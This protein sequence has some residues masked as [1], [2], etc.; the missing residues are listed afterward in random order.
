[1]YKMIIVD[2]EQFSREGMKRLLRWENYDIEIAAV[3][4]NAEEGIEVAKKI[5]PDIIITDI[6]MNAMD[7][8]TMLE[9]IKKFLKCEFI[10]ISGYSV[11]EYA[12]R[13]INAEV[14]NYLLKPVSR[15]DLE[16]AVMKCIMKIKKNT[17]QTMAEQMGNVEYTLDILLNEDIP[18]KGLIDFEQY[19]VAVI[20]SKEAIIK[21][22]HDKLAV[23]ESLKSRYGEV[24]IFFINPSELVIVI[25]AMYENQSVLLDFEQIYH[26]GIALGNN[27]QKFQ[28]VYGNARVAVNQAIRENRSAVLFG[29]DTVIYMNEFYFDA[30]SNIEMLLE[31]GEFEPM[32]T[33]ISRC[34]SKARK[35]G[36]LYSDIISWSE[37]LFLLISDFVRKEEKNQLSLEGIENR[38]REKLG[39]KDNFDF[40]IC[41][42]ILELCDLCEQDNDSDQNPVKDHRI[43]EI[44]S[45]IDE[46]YRENISLKSLA[47]MFWLDQKYLSKLFKR[48]MGENYVEYITRKRIEDAKQ[49]LSE[50]ELTISEI[51]ESVSYDDTNYFTVVFKKYV[52]ITPKE[53]RLRHFKKS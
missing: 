5:K 9:E 24:Y 33:E 16:M 52:G 11:F 22:F 51:A 53:Y 37:K 18:V 34:F 38:F 3:C 25:D 50:E 19:M 8:L 49:M 46:H 13:A 20:K 10:V 42:L 45:Y 40:S 48:H 31:S 30:Y 39:E 14:S 17:A 44:V 2:D 15:T 28:E 1:M 47:S 36:V 41:D 23:F 26:V 12:Q 27:T 6:R 29:E 7:G 21:N 35:E 32:K 4:E 43:L